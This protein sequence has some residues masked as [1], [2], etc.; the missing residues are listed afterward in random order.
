MYVKMLK[1][2][3]LNHESTYPNDIHP[4]SVD[5][6]VTLEAL[7][8]QVVSNLLLSGVIK[9]LQQHDSFAKL[10]VE[11]ET[12]K[13]RLEALKQSDVIKVL[14]EKAP[15][16]RISRP[17]ANPKINQIRCTVCDKILIQTSDIGST[18]RNSW[19]TKGL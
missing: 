18:F 14:E 13:L 7:D 4:V 11:A 3:I 15:S 1:N 17:I 6:K 16:L 10:Q 19:E 12:S 9:I 5:F 8:P 2:A